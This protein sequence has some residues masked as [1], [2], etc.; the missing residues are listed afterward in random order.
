MGDTV[1]THTFSTEL[2]KVV[3]LN[4][5]SNQSMTLSIRCTFEPLSRQCYLGSSNTHPITIDDTRLGIPLSDAQTTERWVQVEGVWK[6]ESDGLLVGQVDL[7]VSK[8]LSGSPAPLV[9]LLH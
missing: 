7:R 8:V 1:T 6:S 2:E 9:V 5:Q 4:S 3:W